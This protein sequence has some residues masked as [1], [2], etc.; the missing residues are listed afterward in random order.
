MSEFDVRDKS[1]NSEIDAAISSLMKKV[2]AKGDDAVPPET[3]VKI[4]NAAINWEKVKHAIDDKEDP[5]DPDM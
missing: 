3:A 1:P 5:F 2:K 4:I